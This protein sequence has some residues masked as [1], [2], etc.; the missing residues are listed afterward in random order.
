MPAPN[1]PKMRLVTK[2][3]WEAYLQQF[4]TRQSSRIG[5]CEPPQEWSVVDGELIGRV[6]YHDGAG[7]GL[8][9]EYWIRDDA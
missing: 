3:E 2:P 9:R 8:P 6:I 1:V 4:P 5:I 7:L